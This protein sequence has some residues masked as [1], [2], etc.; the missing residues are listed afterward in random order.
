M[1]PYPSFTEEILNRKLYF[2]HN[3]KAA[4]NIFDTMQN[5]NESAEWR[6]LRACR[7]L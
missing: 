3:G 4:M 6:A 5:L 2:S 1:L 7:A